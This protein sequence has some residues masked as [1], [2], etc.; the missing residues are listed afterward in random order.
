MLV[1]YNLWMK[2]TA[3][4]ALILLTGCMKAAVK[5]STERSVLVENVFSDKMHEAL[6]LA[7]AECRKHDRHAV[8]VPDDIRDGLAHFECV[9]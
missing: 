4:L 8:Y 9:E 3:L 7:E 1:V 6:T 2:I 5:A